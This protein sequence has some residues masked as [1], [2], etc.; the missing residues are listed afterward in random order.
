MLEDILKSYKQSAS[1][2]DWKKYNKN[3][4]F[5][6]YI[7]HENDPLAENFFAGIVCRFWGYSGR[8][9]NKCAKHVPFEECY[10]CVIDAIRYVLNKRVWENPNSSLYGDK[11]APD[12][13]FHIALKRQLAI[14]LS[15]YNAKR[16]LSNFNTLS[17]DEFHENYN[18]SSDGLL[19]DLD[20]S[21]DTIRTFISEYFEKDEYLNGLFL[22]TICYNNEPYSEKTIIKRLRDFDDKDFNYFKSN[23]DIDDYKL[24]KEVYNLKQMS[25]D[26]LK[27]KLNS[28]LYNIKKEGYFIN[29]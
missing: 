10:D 21:S 20:N 7:K 12:K 28:L 15:K 24:K 22:D 3:D 13:A 27:I 14:M 29:G 19:F 25:P 17:I 8:I 4:L 16:R 1:V 18:D 11:T 5:F 26:F 9:Y 23:Y 6:E 2:I